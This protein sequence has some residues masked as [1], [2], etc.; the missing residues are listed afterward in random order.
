MLAS[1]ASRCEQI[2]LCRCT[3]LHHL[4][5]VFFL[6]LFFVFCLDSFT[7]SARKRESF[8]FEM[9]QRPNRQN[10]W[11]ALSYCVCVISSQVFCIFRKLPVFRVKP[12]LKKKKKKYIT[13]A[14]LCCTLVWLE[15]ITGIPWPNAYNIY[16]YDALYTV[17]VWVDSCEKK[18][19]ILSWDKRQCTITKMFLKSRL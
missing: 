7:V 15:S 2:F 17:C 14:L 8:F 5:I 19:G 9:W 11:N 13:S 4:F 1:S 10:E 18:N 3:R 16:I 12:K 6:L